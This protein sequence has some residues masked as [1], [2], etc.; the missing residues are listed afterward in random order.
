MNTKHLQT[1]LPKAMFAAAIAAGLG[2]PIMGS[3]STVSVVRA[4]DEDLPDVPRDAKKMEQSS[5]SASFHVPARGQVWLYDTNTKEVVHSITVSPNNTYSFNTKKDEIFVNETPGPKTNLDPKHTYQI[6]YVDWATRKANAKASGK[7][8][9]AEKEEEE[10]WVVPKGAKHVAQGKNGANVEFKPEVD[11]TIYLFDRTSGDLLN[12]FKVHKGDSF[13][14]EPKKNGVYLNDKEIL[15]N[16]GM[17]KD[18][19]YRLWFAVKPAS[20]S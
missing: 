8:E 11:G 15:K 12:T 4:A 3:L 16:A 7:G 1:V 14:A 10:T 18:H 9:A 13:V 17:A 2:L 5:D 19:S 6:Y 20:A